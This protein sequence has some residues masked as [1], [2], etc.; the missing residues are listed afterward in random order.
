MSGG[1]AAPSRT[2]GLPGN[3]SGGCAEG[4]GSLW[5]VAA[6]AVLASSGARSAGFGEGSERSGLSRSK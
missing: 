3:A 5:R 6:A 4:I 1:P 2:R